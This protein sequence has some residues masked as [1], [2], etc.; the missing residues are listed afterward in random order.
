MVETGVEVRSDATGPAGLIVCVSPCHAYNGLEWYF[1]CYYDQQRVWFQPAAYVDQMIARSRAP[2]VVACEV[3]DASGRLDV[4]ARKSDDG[5]R[6]VLQV[7]NTCDKPVAAEVAL[8]GFTPA[9][10]TARRKELAGPLDGCNT[11][12]QPERVRPASRAWPHGLRRG[13][14]QA[15][16]AAQSFAVI[17]LK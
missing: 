14:L 3:D 12:E 5:Q 15:T 16:F 1:G 11:L 7:V 2:L 17:E 6:L 9:E 4:V 10:S 13:R 8:A